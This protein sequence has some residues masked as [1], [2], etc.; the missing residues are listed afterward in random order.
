M[1]LRVIESSQ[2]AAGV[3]MDALGDD[4]P[5]HGGVAAAGQADGD[6]QV[7]PQHPPPAR[8]GQ[9]AVGK[10]QEHQRQR[11]GQDR[12]V[13][14]PPA[15][16]PPGRTAAVTQAVH[17]PRVRTGVQAEQ[18]PAGMTSSSQP[19]GLPGWRRA[20]IRPTA[21]IGRL[22]AGSAAFASTFCRASTLSGITAAAS[23]T[24]STASAFAAAAEASQ[25]RPVTCVRGGLP[26]GRGPESVIPV[27][28]TVGWR[29]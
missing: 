6:S 21:P 23:S 18:T 20:T 27:R 7:R 22:I 29:Y 2:A 1:S 15:A 25:E 9:R 12:P 8:R 14:K 10:Q 3:D 19:I 24:T 4:D 26:A 5:H 28:G 13:A 11:D 16:P 17:Q